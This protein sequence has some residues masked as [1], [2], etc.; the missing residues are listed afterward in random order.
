MNQDQKIATFLI[1]HF[2]D[3][4]QLS[5]LSILKIDKGEFLVFGKYHILETKNSYK[6]KPES[7]NKT[8]EFYDI[9]NAIT[10]CIFHSKT[11][12]KE[13]LDIERLDHKL[14]SVDVEISLYNAK[15]NKS[16]SQEH[17]FIQEAKL[18]ELLY[19]KKVIT[20]NLQKLI[21][22][23]KSWQKKHYA[24]AKS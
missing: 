13:C 1:K 16:T 10:W 12:I 2:D 21:N 7:I 9:K 5:N 23:S 11:R 17:R 15:N 18:S 19:K 4:T 14:E 24:K 8:L 3:N 6:L 22:T 20:K